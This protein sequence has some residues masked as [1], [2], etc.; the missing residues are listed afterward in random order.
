V[1]DCY[2]FPEKDFGFV[3]AA[4]AGSRPETVLQ[5]QAISGTIRRLDEKSPVI[6]GRLNE[7]FAAGKLLKFTLVEESG[8]DE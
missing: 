5:T 1:N 6:P 8:K 4:L 3:E 2:S 7:T